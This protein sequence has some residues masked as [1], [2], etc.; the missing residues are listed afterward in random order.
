MPAERAYMGLW[1]PGQ[2]CTTFST[3]RGHKEV[4]RPNRGTRHTDTHIHYV[5]TYITDHSH[6]EF[7]PSVSVSS[8]YLAVHSVPIILTSPSPWMNRTTIRYCQPNSAAI[9]TSRP[10]TELISIPTP[11][12]YSEPY[13]FAIMPKGIWVMT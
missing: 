7:E 4:H 1:G 2:K 11:R 8:L 9:G 10:N 12:K 3:Q 6:P 5:Y 13:F